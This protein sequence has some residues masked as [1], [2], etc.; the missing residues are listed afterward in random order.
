MTTKQNV[1]LHINNAIKEGEIDRKSV[2]K[3]YLT[4]TT[5]EMVDII[6][7]GTGQMSIDWGNGD[8]IEIHTLTP[9]DKY[10]TY[11]FSDAT[12]RTITIKAAISH[13]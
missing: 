4:T 6:I 1:S 10:Y 2:V 5:A 7:N 11:N 3:E 8:P 13:Y 12:L 9:T